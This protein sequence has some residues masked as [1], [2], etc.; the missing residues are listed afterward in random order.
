MLGKAIAAPK[1][2]FG[3]IVRK[4]KMLSVLLASFKRR[5]LFLFFLIQITSAVETVGLALV[6]PMLSVIVIPEAEEANFLTYLT[7]LLNM[8]PERYWLAVVGSAIVVMI[9]F[10]GILVV[11]QSW[12]SFRLV[13]ELRRSWMTGMFDTYMRSRYSHVLSFSQ[14]VLLNNIITEP[15]QA[16]RGIDL[17]IMYV[18]RGCVVLYLY[19]LLVLVSWQVTLMV[20]V[21]LLLASLLMSK[22]T[23]A[24][25]LSV[26]QRRLELNQRVTAAAAEGMSG[27]RQIKTFSIESRIFSEFDRPITLWNSLTLR[28]RIVTSLPTPTL[29]AIIVIVLVGTLS[30]L[31]YGRDTNLTAA[32]PV[33]GLFAI[34][35][36]RM[37]AVVSVLISNRMRI[38]STVPSL[39]LV[40]D[41]TIRRAEAERPVGRRLQFT[42]LT[43]DIQIQRVSFRHEGRDALFENL[44]MTIPRGKLTALV[45]PSGSGKSTVADLL[46]G[47]FQPQQGEI[48][49][50]GISLRD[51]DLLTWRKGIG[52]ASQDTFVFNSSIRDNILV[53]RPE[54][55]E[56]EVVEAARQ[57]NAHDFID[58]MP[59]GYDTVAGDRGVKLSGG[60]RQRIAIARTIIRD[61]E[62]FIFDE[63]TNSLD[64]ESERLVHE[65]IEGLGGEKTVLFITHRM[66]SIRK[67]DLVYRLEN[68][69]ISIAG[70]AKEVL[71]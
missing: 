37:L 59:Q 49:I 9:G 52:F 61:P 26:G 16:A 60:Q 7:P 18:S 39:R 32:I 70:P 56:Q 17:S 40:H 20:T 27:I 33:L 45:G 43:D 35:G 23:S 5:I 24:Y 21:V 50:N 44:N 68:G 11:Y 28:F 30:F 8:F 51:L 55:T 67:A 65:S 63:A 19:I 25:S 15:R 29:E 4:L 22:F 34:V 10:K 36:Q 38:L 57:A 2:F 66:D 1:N 48:L 47:L 12:Y 3:D 42:K 54:A 64:A 13:L 69:R 41:N 53:G 31:V 6:L 14:G 71:V 62:F 58:E 46:L